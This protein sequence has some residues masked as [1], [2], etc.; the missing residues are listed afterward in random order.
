MHSRRR[1]EPA[2]ARRDPIRDAV[3]SR[4]YELF[5]D[6]DR[7]HGHDVD[8]WLQAESELRDAVTRRKKAPDA[9]PS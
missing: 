1:S 8:D 2:P 9:K 3:A 6:R 4:A 5:L 7:A